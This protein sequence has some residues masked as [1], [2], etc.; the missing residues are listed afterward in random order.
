MK[1]VFF[2]SPKNNIFEILLSVP[3]V[4]IVFFYYDIFKLSIFTYVCVQTVHVTC[5]KNKKK[6]TFLK[7]IGLKQNA[8]SEII[9][10]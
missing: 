9:Y 7:V 3:C 5:H 8:F 6:H 2:E 4:I 10:I 1:G